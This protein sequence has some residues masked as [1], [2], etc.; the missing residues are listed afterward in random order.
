MYHTSSFLGSR[1]VYVSALVSGVQIILILTTP[2][3]CLK[4][5]LLKRR[6]IY[7][8]EKNVNMSH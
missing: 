1:L 4:V 5:S 7:I 6:E 3:T 8:Q 2:H